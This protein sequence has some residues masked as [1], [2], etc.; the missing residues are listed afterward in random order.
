LQPTE[1]TKTSTKDKFSHILGLQTLDLNWI[2][3][4]DI[5]EQGPRRVQQLAADSA[6]PMEVADQVL[7]EAEL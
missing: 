7:E 2:S 3:S 5:T 1:R 6:E 4:K